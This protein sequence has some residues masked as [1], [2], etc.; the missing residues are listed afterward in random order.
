VPNREGFLRMVWNDVINGPMK[1]IWI[2]NRIAASKKEPNGAFADAGGA[3]E[4]ITAKGIADRDLSLVVRAEIYKAV[5]SLLY[6]LDDPGVDDGNVFMLQESLLSAD[7]STKRGA[8]RFSAMSP[9]SK[10]KK[11]KSS[12]GVLSLRFDWTQLNLKLIP[13]KWSHTP[14]LTQSPQVSRLGKIRGRE[15]FSKKP[16]GQNGVTSHSVTLLLA[17]CP[18]DRQ[19]AKPTP[20]ECGNPFQHSSQACRPSPRP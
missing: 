8:T 16:A 13:H 10:Q 3:L 20:R 18:P 19:Q 7:P 5:F 14:R 4:R 17:E 9:I 6:M 11:R 12:P 1:G 2:R 15:S